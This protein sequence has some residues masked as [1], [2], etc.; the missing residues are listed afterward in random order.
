MARIRGVKVKKE[1]VLKNSSSNISHSIKKIKENER[2]YT[3]ILVSFFFVVFCFVG[4]FSLRVNTDALLNVEHPN[5]SSGLSAVGGV[6][7]LTS[8][9][10]M[11]DQEGLKSEGV[12]F[13]VENHQNFPV[14]YRIL[15]VEDD[16]MVDK[17]GCRN[18]TFDLS[19][20]HYSLDGVHVQKYSLES[21]PILEDE[22]KKEGKKNFHIQVWVDEKE[23]SS[24][25]HFHGHFVIESI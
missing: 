12:T 8:N 9:H 6:V 11:S 4:Y 25:Q 19:S 15:F 20:I 24:N 10:I 7:T 3:I 18:H 2:K 13:T 23:S 22:I 17:C 1:A 14:R 21:I 16:Y 5:Y